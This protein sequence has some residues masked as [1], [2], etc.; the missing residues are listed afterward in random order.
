MWIASMLPVVEALAA[1][2][3]EIETTSKERWK[4]KTIEDSVDHY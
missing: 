3:G 2:S 4:Y 1:R